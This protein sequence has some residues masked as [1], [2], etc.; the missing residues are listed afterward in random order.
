MKQKNDGKSHEIQSNLRLNV[1][2]E[3]FISVSLAGL[4]VHIGGVLMFVEDWRDGVGVEGTV[5]LLHGGVFGDEAESVGDVG[6]GG[7]DVS[8]GQRQQ[9]MGLAA[10]HAADVGGALEFVRADAIRVHDFR[11]DGLK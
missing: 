9:V 2:L 7:F 11:D 1:C 10:H 5:H 4:A 8:V 6:A 3:F